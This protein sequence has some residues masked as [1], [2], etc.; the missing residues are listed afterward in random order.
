[1]PTTP[2]QKHNTEIKFKKKLNEPYDL[3]FKFDLKISPT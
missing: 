1:M 2:Y 3:K